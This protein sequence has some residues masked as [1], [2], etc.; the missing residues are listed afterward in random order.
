MQCPCMTSAESSVLLWDHHFP[1]PAL[2]QTLVCAK[3]PLPLYSSKLQALCALCFPR[4]SQDGCTCPLM[5]LFT[6]LQ[7]K[8]RVCYQRAGCEQ[9]SLAHQEPAGFRASFI[10]A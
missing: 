8:E 9:S 10:L 6:G 1:P 3:L 4:V 5:S 2:P 7:R